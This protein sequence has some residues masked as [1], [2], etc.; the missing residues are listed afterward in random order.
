MKHGGV[1]IGDT[2]N[3]SVR[4]GLEPRHTHTNPVKWLR[5]QLWL[6]LSMSSGF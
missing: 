6:P 4:P 3:K 5:S 1:G 2:E